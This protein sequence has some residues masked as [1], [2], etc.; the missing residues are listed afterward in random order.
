[1][2]AK[3]NKTVAKVS[4]NFFRSKKNLIIFLMF[5]LS[6]YPFD[7]TIDGNGISASY[8]FLL[9]LLIPI[10][11]RAH[12]E[13]ATCLIFFYAAIFILGFPRLIYQGEMN[14]AM[15]TAFSFG[16]FIAPLLL[17]FVRFKEEDIKIFSYAVITASVFYSLYLIYGFI[18]N[19]GVGVFTMKSLI[20][21]QRFGFVLCLGFF[22]VLYGS[23]F[24]AI[25]KF[26]L[27]IAI[28]SGIMLTFSRASVI[29]LLVSLSVAVFLQVFRMLFR[30]RFRVRFQTIK[31][32]F[33][34]GFLLILVYILFIDVF[35]T[36]FEF[37]DTRLFAKI[38]NMLQGDIVGSEGV[39]WHLFNQIMDYLSVNLL[40][41]SN[42][43][44]M[45]LVFDEYKGGMSTHNQYTDILMR[46]GI[47]GFSVY[48]L[49]LFQILRFYIYDKGV[50]YGLIS[51]LV[52]GLFHE[53]F[54]LGYGGFIFGFLL[55]YAWWMR[56]SLSKS[57][58]VRQKWTTSL[59]KGYGKA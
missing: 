42:F 45:Y 11:T 29:A 4:T 25:T 8:L 57:E 49:L 30:F 54:K 23:A 47:I 12:N 40:T 6:F 21:S 36:L 31:N 5:A 55:S 33:V 28:L 43:S 48:A 41:G 39:R 15:R 58:L 2:S 35:M 14:Y 13:K 44:G 17:L 9:L 46:T 52:Y 27:I 20:G 26:I 7:I 51:I 10:R 53:T 16:A 38:A 56:R 37:Y 32:L 34:F 19:P 18:S 59:S 22:L 1:M 24:N 50:F 3:K